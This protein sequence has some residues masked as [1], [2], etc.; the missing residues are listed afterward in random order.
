MPIASVEAMIVMNKSLLLLRRRNVPARGQWWFAGGRIRKGESLEETLFRKVQEETG[1]DVTAR[2]LVN[3]YSRVFPERHDIAIVF[4]CK[5]KGR[6]V[7]LNDEHSEYK[8]VK[9]VPINLHPYI[10]RVIEDSRFRKQGHS[11]NKRALRTR[12]FQ[13]QD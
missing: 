5:C 8:F 1:L 6:K 13:K 12:A 2:K 4:L 11:S 10:L 9:K 3:V 7:V